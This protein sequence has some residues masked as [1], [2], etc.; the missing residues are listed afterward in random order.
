METISV[1]IALDRP[2]NYEYMIMRNYHEEH[3]QKSNNDKSDLD[4]F[5][6]RQR[7]KR[8]VC[9]TRLLLT[10]GNSCNCSWFNHLS[11]SFRSHATNCA[12]NVWQVKHQ[13]DGTKHPAIAPTLSSR[14]SHGL[15][16]AERF[17][18]RKCLYTAI[19]L[20]LPTIWSGFRWFPGQ[21]TLLIVIR[22]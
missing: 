22:C 18:C 10:A 4:A 13:N 8:G 15:S 19:L 3:W 9:Q 14:S 6:W 20:P 16:Q 11:H 7:L 17:L 12:R 1:A 2:D 5:S 21:L